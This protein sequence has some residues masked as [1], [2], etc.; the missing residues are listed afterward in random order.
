[1][2]LKDKGLIYSNASPEPGRLAVITSSEAHFSLLHA[3][4]IMGLGDKSLVKIS[5][6][7]NYRMDVEPLVK[8]VGQLNQLQHFIYEEIKADGK[9][10]IS[11]TKLAGKTVLRLVAISPSV[12]LKVL[13]ET[14][15][16]A[17][18]QAGKFPVR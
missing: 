17:R 7:K 16:I 10:S 11:L 18:S 9:H 5:V 13:M 14:V 12:I 4:R 3:L 2:A 6:D 8:V 15:S 1:M